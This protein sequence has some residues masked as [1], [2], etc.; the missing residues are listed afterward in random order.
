MIK[1]DFRSIKEVEHDFDAFF[2]ETFNNLVEEWKSIK[3]P[4]KASVID[5]IGNIVVISCLS[6]EYLIDFDLCYLSIVFGKSKIPKPFML[7]KFYKCPKNKYFEKEGINQIGEKYYIREKS[8][9]I[10]QDFRLLD[11]NQKVITSCEDLSKLLIDKFFDAIA[12]DIQ[13]IE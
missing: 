3:M 8:F 2:K 11:K 10:G 5:I 4:F 7:I 1:E 12:K 9:V 13:M 6:R